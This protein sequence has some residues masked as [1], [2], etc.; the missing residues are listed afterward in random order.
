MKSRFIICIFLFCSFL[1]ISQN[2]D[3]VY[4]GSGYV[5]QSFY[6]LSNGE[7]SNVD[8]T[9][10]D[11]A[12]SL[13]QMGS[14]IRVNDGKGVELYKYHIG[15]TSHW[16]MI[17][18]GVVDYLTF[19]LN[20]SDTSW[21]YGALNLY[22]T[23]AFDLG[24][25]I[26]NM[27]NHHVVGDSLYIIKTI[28][29][30]WKKLWIER[31]AGGVY[32]FHHANLDGSSA[33]TQNIDKSNYSNKSF[34]YYNIEN[35]SIEDRE[36][37]M[38][39]WD[40]TFTKYVTPVQGMAYGVTGVLQN[41]GVKVAQADQIVSP[42]TYSDYNSHIF[43]TDINIIGYD[44]KSYDMSAGGY[45]LSD[46]LCYFIEDNNGDI[47]RIVFTGFAGTSTGKIV[48]NIENLSLTP[49]YLHDIYKNQFEIYPNPTS[50]SS[51]LVF[52]SS[53]YAYL[54]IHDL[55]GKK[56]YTDAF[57]SGFQSHKID[58]KDFDKGVY[59]VNLIIDGQ[60][61]QQKLIVQ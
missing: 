36:P 21:S 55:T 29:G 2:S 8:N 11:L 60:S 7:I 52:E 18:A 17:N 61:S 50:E 38:N 13:S 24:W 12:F 48:F 3:S 6:S 49:T 34:V 43:N 39:Q 32:T 22:Q 30:N 58:L 19:P 20:N 9:N 33:I 45:V 14:S 35:N 54:E 10:W 40:I 51:F 23:S 1:A 25:G 27:V 15:D 28:N 46:D 44:W 47:F 5:N 31:L 16:S 57:L 26:Y 37:A 53:Q 56:M 41:Y 42:L 4:M 59:I